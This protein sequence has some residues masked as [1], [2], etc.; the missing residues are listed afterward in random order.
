METSRSDVRVPDDASPEEAAAIAAVVS[1]YLRDRRAA[2]AAAAADGEPSWDGDRWT[3]AGR[4]E[5]TQGRSVRV[6]DGA[7]RDAWTAAGR[8]DRF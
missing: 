7:P 8:T 4:V 2:A 3:F 6:P 1:A 5:G